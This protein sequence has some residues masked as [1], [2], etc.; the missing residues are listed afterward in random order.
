[1]S[2]HKRQCAVH[3]NGGAEEGDAQAGGSLKA[4]AVGASR[5]ASASRAKKAS[6]RNSRRNADGGD[7]SADED[8]EDDPIS[9]DFAQSP[10]H[11]VPGATSFP[12]Q[13]SNL[14]VPSAPPPLLPPAPYGTDLSN[15]FGRVTNN[16]NFGNITHHLSALNSFT[17]QQHNYPSS[18][19]SNG[20]ISQHSSPRFTARDM[21][22]HGSN[23]SRFSLR[24]GGSFDQANARAISTANNPVGHYPQEFWEALDPAAKSASSIV[25]N[26]FV[27]GP[28]VSHPS[29]SL[30]AEV[31]GVGALANVA[32]TT[33]TAGA[34]PLFNGGG[35]TTPRGEA[36]R[37]AV[38]SGPLSPFSSV[39]LTSSMSPYLSAFSNARDT[40]FVASPSR[41][42]IPGTPGSNLNIFDWTMRPPSKPASSTN[43][44]VKR[45]SISMQG[46]GNSSNGNGNSSKRKRDDDEA[47]RSDDVLLNADADERSAAALLDSLRNAGSRPFQPM[48]TMPVDNNS[49]PSAATAT[50]TDS[51]AAS[52][53]NTTT[54]TVQ[55]TPN[56]GISSQQPE[57]FFEQRN[58]TVGPEAFLLRL[59]GGAQEER[60]GTVG[61]DRTI[62]QFLG[63][64]SEEQSLSEGFAHSL[65]QFG[66]N[67][68]NNTTTP[69]ISWESIFYGNDA[70]AETSMAPMPTATSAGWLMS[71][72]IQQIINSFSTNNPES[73]PGENG[74][75]FSG[76][77]TEPKVRAPFPPEATQ[78]QMTNSTDV[79]SIALEKAMADVKNPFY[80]P[81]LLFRPCYQ[82]DHWNLPPTSRLSML[83]LH[84]QQNLLKHFPVIHEPTFRLDTTP[85]CVAFAMTML[86]CH[87]HGRMWWTGEEVVARKGESHTNIKLEDSNQ[88][89]KDLSATTYDEEDGQELIRPIVMTDKMDR[90][91]RSFTSHAKSAHDK[92]SI[93][94]ALTLF[95]ANQFLSSDGSTRDV[96]GI[97]H[98]SLVTLA[99]KAG[100]FDP[101]EAHNGRKVTYTGEEVL[102][103][104]IFES[105]DLCFSMSYL[106]ACLPGCSNEE[107]VWRRWCE[108]A[109]RRRTAHLIFVM[110]T[111]ASMDAGIGTHVSLEEIAHLHLPTPDT[112]WRAPTAKAWKQALNDYQGPTL[113]EAMTELL[114]P[115]QQGKESN[116]KS[117]YGS[118]GPFSRLVVAVALLRGIV[119]L[120]E[121]RKRRISSPSPLQA[122]LR[123]ADTRDEAEVYKVALT[124]WRAAW[125]Q[126]SLCFAASAHL[127]REKAAKLG[128][129]E[130]D[131]SWLGNHYL[132]ASRTASGATPLSDDALPMYW[133]SILLLEYAVAKKKIKEE[134]VKALPGLL[135][136]A[137]AFKS[138][139]KENV[140]IE[141]TEEHAQ[142]KETPDYR[143]LLRFSKAYVLSGEKEPQ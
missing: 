74:N 31:T 103:S 65:S 140:K 6:Q 117:L 20:T 101:K 105:K 57:S 24:K 18:P 102:Q 86:G 5:K 98:N 60:T 38:S 136:L 137:G 55:T 75:Y 121:D 134:D 113:D 131:M 4:A 92:F 28:P 51:P 27:S 37:F 132:F 139:R 66:A 61:P 76:A 85:G 44:S 129:K 19:E 8:E 88:Q 25:G 68:T 97:N 100:L 133:M 56:I 94:V 104:T 115:Q 33:A 9:Q 34:N 52:S 89:N 124:R 29:F 50:S 87:R 30:A 15:D 35:V 126:D 62:L 2:R 71:P 48:N 83:A 46:G 110:D 109:A 41:G 80:V 23:G 16:T 12:F 32:A 119:H 42:V 81:P 123:G 40:P 118:H 138:S 111:I 43:N 77:P 47:S 49:D 112:V 13:Q 26:D 141:S 107:R 108:L 135:Q 54:S 142:E 95:Q 64:D 125:D 96:A 63:S 122:W 69:S 3:L 58:A 78:M 143:S 130:D 7:P 73:V 114:Q 59:Q 39:A 79:T 53:A 36:H 10:S 1:M 84:S 11:L 17:N 21:S 93:V 128:L 120:L 72:G 99:R 82:V 67:N 116:P 45:E 91:M 106:P 90:L 22:R 70:G 14:Q 127:A